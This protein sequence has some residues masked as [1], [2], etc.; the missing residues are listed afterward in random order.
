[1]S[2]SPTTRRDFLKKSVVSSL[3]LAVGWRAAT[4]GGTARAD[5]YTARVALTKGDDRADNAFRALQM[6]KKDIATA[7]GNKHVIIK[8]NFVYYSTLLSCTH[9]NWVEGVLEFLKSIGKTNIA[10]A[11]SS[12][13][14]STMAGYDLNNYWSLTKKYPVKLMDLNQEGFA[15][16]QIWQTTNSTETVPPKTIRISRMYLN[17]N[18]FI[19][20]CAPMKTH[21]T[22]VVTLST[23][24]IAMSAPVIDVGTAWSQTGVR[25]D[26]AWMHGS[27]DTAPG[28]YQVLNDNVY[29]MVKV[30]GIH[31]HLAAIDGYQGMQGDGPVSGYAV[32]PPQKLGIASLDWLAADRVALALMGSNNYRLLNTMPYPACL[33]YC[34]QAGMG[35]WN[36]DNIQVIGEPITGNVYNYAASPSISS[37]LGLRQ[38]PRE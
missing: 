30:Y 38:T 28:N 31:P 22:A 16:A 37:Q 25:A 18:N 8:P 13:T 7:I 34:W 36:I 19:I 12:S 21:N 10:I 5:T 24:N 29:R 3:G 26:K 35:E 15:N 2:S 14:G 23:K 20:S 27:S 32:S 1:M 9:V 4:L 6:F 17:A 11:E 33:N